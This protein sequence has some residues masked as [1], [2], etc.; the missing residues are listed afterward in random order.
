M[1]P[2][3]TPN[4]NT[5]TINGVPYLVISLAQFMVPLDWDPSSNMFLAVAAP[6][7]AVQDQIAQGVGGFPAL[8]QGKDG[9]PPG[10]S[11][12]INF[13]PLEADDPTPD[14]ASWSTIGTNLYQLNLALHRGQAGPPGTMTILKATDFNGQPTPGMLLAV[15]AAGTGVTPVSPLV[16]DRYVPA[17]IKAVPSGNAAYTICP[18]TVPPQLFDWRPIVEGWD[19]VTPQ[20]TDCAVDLVARLSNSNPDGGETTGNEVCRGKGLAGSTAAQI[21]N[22]LGGP[23]PGSGDAFDR[24][25]AGQQATVFIRA[26]RTAGSAYFTT[27]GTNGR[28]GVRV[29]PCPTTVGAVEVGGGTP[30]AGPLTVKI[31]A[32]GSFSQAVPAWANYVDAVA[33]GDGG[34]GGSGGE[35]AG[36]AGAGTTV[37]VGTNTLT[38]P[39]GAGGAAGNS[40]GSAAAAGAGAG[41][42]AYNGNTY[43]G[44]DSVAAQQAGSAPGGG[45]G[46]GTA[47]GL[48]GYGASAGQWE[49][50]TYPVGAAAGVETITGNVGAGGAP[51]AGQTVGSGHGAPGAVWL[52]FRQ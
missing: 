16:G 52:T 6:N 18:I 25:P 33:L 43:T 27:D 29:A 49:S 9:P 17:A 15:N 8:L 32:A 24:V 31:T 23:P 19:V 26:E 21:V 13:N 28:F 48:Y 51:I 5:T 44:G 12:I 3:Q 41:T 40:S 35:G 39:G 30:T 47:A 11:E 34:G 36:V 42:Y 50:A 14:S 7:A 38:A 4:W 37:T 46:A 1:T 20:G 45:G 10:L 22:L 2:P